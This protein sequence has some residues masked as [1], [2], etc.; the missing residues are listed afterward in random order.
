MAEP[1]CSI[2]REPRREECTICT[3][4]APDAVFTV[5]RYG[6]TGQAYGPGLVRKFPH[7]KPTTHRSQPCGRRK[8]MIVS[9]VRWDNRQGYYRAA[10]AQVVGL[11]ADGRCRRQAVVRRAWYP[12]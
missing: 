3:A 12:R 11:Q 1:L 6:D 2:S 5:C 4:V 7:H 10:G 8:S 9:Q